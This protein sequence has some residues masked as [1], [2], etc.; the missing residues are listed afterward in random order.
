MLVPFITDSYQLAASG[1]DNKRI[2][3]D[4]DLRPGEHA[5][6]VLLPPSPSK[7]RLDGVLTSLP[8]DRPLRTARLTL[9]MPPQPY[10]SVALHQVQTWTEKFDPSSG[11]WITGP[12]KP[13]EEI[14]AVPY[15]YVKYR[16]E[17]KYSGETT[18][19]VTS[20]GAEF[21]RV[22]LNGKPVPEASNTNISFEFPLAQYAVT[23]LNRIEIACECFGSSSGGPNLGALR[24]IDSVRYG[25]SAQDVSTIANW[26]IQRFPAAMRGRE[27]DPDFSVGGWKLADLND[28]A[29]SKELAP[30]FTWCRAEFDLPSPVAAWSVPWKVMFEAERDALLYLNG[31]F[32]GR[33]VTAG[34][35]KDFYLP[36]AYLVAGGKQKNLLTF[37]LA[38]A[39]H[40][41]Y[42]RTLR[43]APYEE[44]AARRSRIEFEF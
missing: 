5:L 23:G 15:G 39:D 31:K 17:F 10:Q 33:Y 4:L 14:G 37:M 24:G 36:E 1:A 12:A 30:A 16:G 32:L 41:G 6:T 26:Q 21:K 9:T 35:Q 34:P 27:I 28:V 13:L 11:A 19:S 3:A 29:S 20:F 22:F 43:I 42:I 44:F 8:Y 18:M 38:Y 2:W 40:P 7:C 25:R